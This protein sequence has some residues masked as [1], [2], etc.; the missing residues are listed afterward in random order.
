MKCFNLLFYQK[1][2]HGELK[3]KDRKKIEI[4]L[5]KCKE[6]RE[7][8]EEMKKEE[9]ELRELFMEKD[10]DFTSL[11]LEKIYKVEMERRKS[12]I[13]FLYLLIFLGIPLI[14]SFLLEFLRSIPFFGNLLSP[15]FYIPSIFF[16]G[17]NKLL[18]I[19]FELLL[20]KSGIL[21]ILILVMFLFRN[22]RVKLETL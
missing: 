8:V 10:I 17:I 13:N 15:L 21:S 5:S 1:F 2:I 4:H 11:I 20:F 19:D 3:E 9:I 7:Q 16:A 18:N 6:C 12:K 14:S 22:L